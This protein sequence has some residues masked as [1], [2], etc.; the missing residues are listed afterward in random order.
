M[1]RRLRRFLMLAVM[2]CTAAPALA[3]N[4]LIEAQ[5]YYRDMRLGPAID[6]LEQCRA[7][8]LPGLDRS[9]KTAALR[10]LSISYFARGDTT[11]ARTA[12]EDLLAEDRRSRSDPLE[13]PV[14]FQDWVHD[15]RP[16]LWHRKW[17][18]RITGGALI[19]GAV[20]CRLA[21]CFS[22]D[23]RPLPGANEFPLP[24]SN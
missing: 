6:V 19:T 24:P 14:F 11:L 4:C 21:G 10:L 23:P 16:K 3:Q 7:E 12:V 2:A 15:L 17:W 1:V 5:T 18:V 8:G 20:V 22:S 13:D 9:Q